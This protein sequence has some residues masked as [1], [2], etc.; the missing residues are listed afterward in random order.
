[1]AVGLTDNA[2]TD[3]IAQRKH[4]EAQLL[5][6]PLVN[7]AYETNLTITFDTTMVSR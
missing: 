6:F 5:G 2:R 7:S 1:V 3:S 4:L